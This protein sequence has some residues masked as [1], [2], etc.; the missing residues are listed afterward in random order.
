MHQYILQRHSIRS[1]IQ[2]IQNFYTAEAGIKKALYYIKEEK[3]INWRT[4]TLLAN[5]PIKD[6]IF[7]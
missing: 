6:T 1:T 7:W 5:E 3:G 2:K 4:G